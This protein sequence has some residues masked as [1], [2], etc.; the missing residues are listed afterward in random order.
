MSTTKPHHPPGPKHAPAH[1]TPRPAPA[2]APQAPAY[3]PLKWSYPFTTGDGKDA[4]DAHSFFEALSNAGDGFF[5]LGANGIWHGGIHFDAA[6]GKILKQED[7]VRAIADGEVVAYRLDSQYPV[8]KYQDGNSCMYSTGFVLVRHKLALPPA[9]NTTNTPAASPTP[10]AT[11]GSAASG[12]SAAHATPANGASKPVPAAVPADET[13]TFFSLYMHL[14]DWRTY[15]AAIDAPPTSNTAGAANQPA[16]PQFKCSPFWKGDKRYRVS[17]SA[18]DSQREP[19]TFNFSLPDSLRVDSPDSTWLPS[20]AISE[21][22]DLSGGAL[23]PLDPFSSVLGTNSPSQFRFDQQPSAD[24]PKSKQPLAK[25][26]QVYS[27]AKGE[28]IGLLLHGCEVKLGA[29]SEKDK[30]WA[31]IAKIIKGEPVGVVVGDP[32]DQRVPTGWVK[33]DQFDLL[34]DPQPLDT[35]VVLDTPYPI[36]AGTVVGYLGEYQRYREASKLPPA[37]QR[38]IMHLEVFAGPELPAF[39]KKSQARAKQLPDQKTF[40]EVSAGATLVDVAQAQE[41][42]KGGLL[43]KPLAKDSGN[44]PWVKVQPTQVTMPP[45][46]PHPSGHGHS[47]HASHA[48]VKPI[49][50]PVGSPVWVERALSGKTT[51]ADIKGW[52]DFPLQVSN[53]KAPA[54]G[55]DEVYSRGELDKFGAEAKAQD[56]KQAHWWKITVGTADGNS[57]E[58]WVCDTGHPLVQWHSPWEWPGFELID[59]TSVSLVDAF[60]RHLYVYDMLFDGDKEQFEPSALS[61]NGSALV[62]KLE[63]VVDRLG[64]NDGKVSAQELGRAQR[65]RWVA[66]ALSHLVVRYES[67]WGGDLSKW[68]SLSSLMKE[69]KYIWQS[70]LERIEKLRWWDKVHGVAGLP[71]DAAVYH[72]HPVGLVGNFSKPCDCIKYEVMYATRGPAYRDDQVIA[73]SHYKTPIDNSPGRLAGNSRRHGDASRETQKNVIDILVDAARDNGLD[74]ND[75]AMLLAMA[76]VESGFNPDAAAGTTTASG[77]GQFVD[78]TAKVYG[79]TTDAQRFDAKQGASALM[80]HYLENKRVSQRRYSGREMYVMI[81]ALH[82]DGPSLAYGGRAISETEVMP[83]YDLY[84]ANICDDVLG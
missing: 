79:I 63:K 57:R 40:L 76:R 17:T 11:P 73:K 29:V 49:E 58:G 83:K 64:N 24:K 38:S 15:K 33:V 61:V 39:I 51:N 59:N 56:D 77:L 70:E 9:Q 66:Q 12:T 34:I 27:K 74:R 8:L 80:M 31:P 71:G 6:T 78:A 82:H 60:K 35:V 47:S 22:T 43:L 19:S 48:K 41:A 7:G 75:L 2:P 37:P 21:G 23:N 44:G 36:N 26:A 30:G 14:L 55:F 72:F 67:E 52:K 4:V 68:D 62:T 25:G 65:V 3:V 16:A 1:P 32:V 81:Y 18:A 84:L 13:L 10:T 53:A 5:P 69:R 54:A 50:T 28:A 42:I 20:G 45:P 46:T